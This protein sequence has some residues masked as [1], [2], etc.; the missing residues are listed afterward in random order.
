MRSYTWGLINYSILCLIIISQYYIE[1]TVLN[2]IQNYIEKIEYY[3]FILV[4]VVKLPSTS[5]NRAPWP[6]SKLNEVYNCLILLYHSF[7]IYIIIYVIKYILYKYHLAYFK[8]TVIL[9]RLKCF[10]SFIQHL[11]SFRF[12]ARWWEY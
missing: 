4:T 3:N 1:I 7:Y 11:L 9:L 6:I 8:Y 10:Y 2:Y 5:R 12:C